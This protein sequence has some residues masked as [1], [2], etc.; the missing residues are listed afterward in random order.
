MAVV[1][2]RV[3]K[4]LKKR[5]ER[6]RLIKEY[7]TKNPEATKKEVMEKFQ[8]SDAMFYTIRKKLNLKPMG[9]A[10]MSAMPAPVKRGRK[11]KK[12]SGAPMNNGKVGTIISIRDDD[13]DMNIEITKDG[14]RL[15]RWLGRDSKTANTLQLGT[16]V[17]WKALAVLQDTG[18]FN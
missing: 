3:K 8:V 17:P 9:K 6:T 13:M 18:L 14:I 1:K 15:N 16:F 7:L 12:D 2:P 11:P 10:K 5:G 4:S